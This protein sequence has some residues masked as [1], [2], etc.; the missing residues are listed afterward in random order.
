MQRK[1]TKKESDIKSVNA[2]KLDNLS[3]SSYTS[4]IN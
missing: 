4:K 1:F 3:S 2:M